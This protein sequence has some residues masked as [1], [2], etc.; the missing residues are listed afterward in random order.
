MARGRLAHPEHGCF[1]YTAHQDTVSR[2]RSFWQQLW[3]L[4]VGAP[5]S[6]AF[7]AC[8]RSMEPGKIGDVWSKETYKS[9]YRLAYNH[10]IADFPDRIQT[11]NAARLLLKSAGDPGEKLHFGSW[12]VKV[13]SGECTGSQRSPYAAKSLVKESIYRTDFRHGQTPEA[14][15]HLETFRPVPCLQHLESFTSAKQQPHY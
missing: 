10:N 12:P 6:L 7:I 3:L 1:S 9:N 2:V 11:A 4:R 5:R 15:P 13:T 8:L 14:D